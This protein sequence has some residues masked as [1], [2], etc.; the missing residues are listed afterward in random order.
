MAYFSV[1]TFKEFS[2]RDNGSG[3]GF[4]S[5]KAWVTLAEK[6]FSEPPSPFS[7]LANRPEGIYCGAEQ[8]RPLF[9]DGTFAFQFHI[10]ES[11]IFTLRPYF[12]SFL[13]RFG[14]GIK[15]ALSRL[16]KDQTLLKM[17]TKTS[18]S[19]LRYELTWK[20]VF[21]RFRF[22]NTNVVSRV[23]KIGTI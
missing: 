11:G 14:V 4:E 19:D 6:G 23:P 18:K 9:K 5:L 20:K 7:H 17:T 15:Y 13:S 8:A 12:N 3:V 2:L 22:Q 21:H 16:A 1:L 10:H